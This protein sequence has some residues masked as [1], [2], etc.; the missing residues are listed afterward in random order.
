MKD[1]EMILPVTN[2]RGKEGEGEIGRSM[3]K[4]K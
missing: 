3:K 2:P 1:T 4:L